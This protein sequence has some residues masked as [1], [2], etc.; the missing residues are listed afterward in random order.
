MRIL[1][2]IS[3]GGYFGAENMLVNL[4]RGLNQLGLYSVVGVFENVGDPHI[5]VADRARKNSLPVILIPCT[6]KFDRAAVKRLRSHLQEEEIDIIH[7]HGYKAS[8]Y[9]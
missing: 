1:H 4:A 6:G 7:T 9:G 5:E 2:L 8:F 3:S